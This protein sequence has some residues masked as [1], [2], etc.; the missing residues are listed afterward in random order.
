MGTRF[1]RASRL[2]ISG[3]DFLVTVATD[4]FHFDERFALF[5]PFA[6]A[7]ATGF[8]D[9]VARG[10]P[11]VGV[12]IVRIL[13]RG[14]ETL[15]LPAKKMTADEGCTRVAVPVAVDCLG[16]SHLALPGFPGGVAGGPELFELL[17]VAEGVHGLPEAVVGEGLD[18]AAGDQGFDGLALEHPVVVFNL[19]D[20]FG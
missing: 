5:I 18:L 12:R 6:I 16:V 7:S 14:H 8:A 4:Q 15:I 19:G 20:D 1:V 10:A 9:I 11:S 2:D 3:L 13:F 17:L